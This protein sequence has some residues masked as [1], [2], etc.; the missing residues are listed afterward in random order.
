MLALSFDF[1]DDAV[2]H[3][4]GGT[5]PHF[6]PPM[7]RVNLVR[8]AV[9]FCS[10]PRGTLVG[11]GWSVVSMKS[12]FHPSNGPRLWFACVLIADYLVHFA[13]LCYLRRSNSQLHA[14]LQC[15][16]PSFQ[17]YSTT[18]CMPPACTLTLN[19]IVTSNL[20]ASASSVLCA[21]QYAEP[22]HD[23]LLPRFAWWLL[24]RRAATQPYRRD[25]TIGGVPVARITPLSSRFRRLSL[26]FARCR[27]PC[28]CVSLSFAQ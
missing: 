22:T 26:P 21:A 5:T 15:C 10:P 28:G 8:A 27:I 6:P 13:F 20:Y 2:H 24:E 9:R 3:F 17:P 4:V 14:I 12:F 19:M 25:R 11:I 18:K 1:V 23:P 16:V 7:A